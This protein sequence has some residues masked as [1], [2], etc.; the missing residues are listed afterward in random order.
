MRTLKIDKQFAWWL[1]DRS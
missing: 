1:T